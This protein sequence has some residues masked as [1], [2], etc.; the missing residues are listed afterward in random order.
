MICRRSRTAARSHPRP[1]WARALATSAAGLAVASVGAG[2]HRLEGQRAGVDAVAPAGG[3][4]PVAEDMTQMTAAP[5]ADHLGAAQQPALV[6]PQLDCRL[7]GRLE[8]A[9]PARAGCEL[10]VRTEQLIPAAGAAVRAV[11][12]GVEVSPGEG[13]LG[14]PPA[15]HVVLLAGQFLPPLLIGL[16][17]LG[18]RSGLRGPGAAHRR[19]LPAFGSFGAE[20]PPAGGHWVEQAVQPPSFLTQL[21]MGPPRLVEKA[22]GVLGGHH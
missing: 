3:P 22:E 11:T 13:W 4:W 6:R 17:D 7:A 2:R 16:L 5:A 10:G 14:V 19:S 20:H 9:R 12:L 15:Q 21:R 8:E 18:R 1:A